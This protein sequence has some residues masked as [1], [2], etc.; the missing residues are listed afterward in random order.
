[1][2]ESQDISNSPD[3][4]TRHKQ[5]E[6]E[7]SR[8]RFRIAISN[9]LR[10]SAARIAHLCETL[11]TFED[12]PSLLFAISDLHNIRDA[13]KH[14]QQQIRSGLNP[15]TMMTNPPDLGLLRH[16][17]RNPLNQ[18][19]GY[20]E[21]LEEE[22]EDRGAL[23]WIE[24]FQRLQIAA[25]QTLLLINDNLTQ[26]RFDCVDPDTD[27]RA[28]GTNRLDRTTG[29]LEIK[30]PGNILLVDDS[31]MN[32]D[33][34]SRRLRRQGYNVQLA[35]DGLEALE[36][37]KKGIFDLILLDIVMPEMDGYQTLEKLKSNPALSDIPVL[38]IS[39]LDDTESIVKCIEMGA[40]DYLPK[41]FDPVILK[42]RIGSSLE[43]KRLRD[44]EVEY[45][46]QVAKITTAAAAVENNNYRHE[47]LNEIASR[48]D[49][50]GQL[51]R[52]FQKMAHEIY[53]REERLRQLVEELKIEVD[54][55]KK[56]RQVAAITENDYFQKL[57]ERA[58]ELRERN[59]RAI[60]EN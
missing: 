48:E 44:Q 25:N 18:I 53:A 33:M 41:P 43:K 23:Q 55:A 27:L 50:L 17:L 59:S 20:S 21:M 60:E 22:A 28:F 47:Y 51:A 16:E 5:A 37:A 35:S 14:L 40:V 31:A 52:V 56:A 13:S 15:Q 7:K 36:K 45:L 11:L 3:N 38:M 34:L 42:A 30:Q 54:E 29:K 32:R 26:A 9:E 19:I 24:E 12:D 46:R 8:L 6:L 1:M 39:A 10:I 49:E 57:K 4:L 2:N 58:Q